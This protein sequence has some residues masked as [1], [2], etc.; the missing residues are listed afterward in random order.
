MEITGYENYLIYDDGRVFSKK[1][2]KFLKYNKS[3][4]GYYDVQLYKNK[5]SKHLSIHR[6]IG[7]HYI[8]NPQNL[9]QVDHINRIRTDNRIE[10]LRW[11]S[12]SKNNSNIIR[13]N[14]SGLHH[15]RKTKSNTYRICI[16][17]NKLFY[18]LCVK[19][20]EKAIIQRDLMLSMF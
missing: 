17:R 12:I 14:T 8:P 11:V 18:S 16:K 6:L 9:P 2:N 13:P 20:K 5:K 4:T 1:T 15:I 7:L 19:T 3:N 10:N